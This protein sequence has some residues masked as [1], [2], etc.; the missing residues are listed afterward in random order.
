[1]C[2]FSQ[3]KVNKL[4][5]PHERIEAVVDMSDLDGPIHANYENLDR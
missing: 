5:V 4:G 2:C 3:E 1:M